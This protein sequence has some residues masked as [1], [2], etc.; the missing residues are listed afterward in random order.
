MP[1]QGRL[2]RLLRGARGGGRR[3]DGGRLVPDLQK[4]RCRQAPVS[5]INDVVDLSKVE[6]GRMD[7]EVSAS[8]SRPP[9]T[10][11]LV[12][13][14]E[15]AVRRGIT[16]GRRLVDI[17]ALRTLTPF[18]APRPQAITPPALHAAPPLE[19]QAQRRSDRRRRDGPRRTPQLPG[20]SSPRNMLVVTPGKR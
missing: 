8:I 10:T 13:V 20:A 1:A 19:P 9:S 11:P 6:A 7:L 14:R 15:R 18:H 12:L 16:L 5:L 2:P 4:C 3:L 17:N